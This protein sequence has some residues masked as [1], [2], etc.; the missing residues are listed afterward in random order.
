MKSMRISEF[1]II[2]RQRGSERV[3]FKSTIDGPIE[4]IQLVL[5]LRMSDAIMITYNININ[6]G[7]ICLD[8]IG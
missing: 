7:I 5:Y 4:A 8:F 6:I 2:I 1:F 3:I